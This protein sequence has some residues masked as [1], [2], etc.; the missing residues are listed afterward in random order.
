MNKERF[1]LGKR[2][3]VTTTDFKMPEKERTALI[4]HLDALKFDPVW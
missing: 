4:Q 1:E 3:N 2:F